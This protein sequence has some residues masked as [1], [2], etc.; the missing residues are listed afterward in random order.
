MSRPALAPQRLIGLTGPAGS[1]KD[2]VA[3][4]IVATWM[5]QSQ[6]QALQ[7]SFGG[8]ITFADPIHRMLMTLLYCMDETGELCQYAQEREL[9]EQ[10]IPSLGVSYRHLAQ[11][12]GT[13]WGQQCIGRDVWL[14]VAESKLSHL[15]RD[16]VTHVVV[17]DVRFPREAD[18]VRARGG[19]IWRIERPGIEPVREHVSESGMASIRS[20]RVIVNDSGIIELAACVSEALA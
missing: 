3:D 19:E 5:H 12:L 15:L 10:P 18:W 2:T 13:E 14:R 20:D 7:C 16:G 17:S 6:R 4:L 11:T 1:G 8:S 9:K